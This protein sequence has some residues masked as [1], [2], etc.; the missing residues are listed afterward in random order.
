MPLRVWP[1]SARRDRRFSIVADRKIFERDI[2]NDVILTKDLM[3]FQM[4]PGSEKIIVNE[5]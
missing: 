2:S 5:P 1:H 3:T 4:L